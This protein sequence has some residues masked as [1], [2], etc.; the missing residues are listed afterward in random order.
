MLYDKPFFNAQLDEEGRPYADVYVRDV[1]DDIKPI[2][3][4]SK[5]RLGY[6]TQKPVALLERIIEASSSPGDMVLDPFCGC[7]TTIDRRGELRATLGGRSRY[8]PS[9]LTSSGN[10]V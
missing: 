8:P 10:G 6:P 4:V 1:W 7:G 9:R 3:N 2:I 5:E